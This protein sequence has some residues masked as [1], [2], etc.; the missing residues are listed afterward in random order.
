MT[1]YEI[2]LVVTLLTWF[3]YICTFGMSYLNELDD[4]IKKVI[5]AYYLQRLTQTMGNLAIK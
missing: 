4:Y 3:C 1:L 5:V 2:W